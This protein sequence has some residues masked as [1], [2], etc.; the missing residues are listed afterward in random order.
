MLNI[1]LCLKGA[2]LLDLKRCKI[3]DKS[4]LS[5]AISVSLL[6]DS[7]HAKAGSLYQHKKFTL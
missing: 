1:E 6:I 7:L 5:L 3:R 4:V 2:V